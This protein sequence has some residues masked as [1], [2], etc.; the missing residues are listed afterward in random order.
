MKQFSEKIE[1]IITQNRLFTHQDR[2]LVALSGGA[3]SVALLR[4]LLELGYRCEAA[5]CNFQ[6]RGNES[7]R[8]ELFVRWLCSEYKVLL[9]VEHFDTSA[10][11]EQR[12]VSIEMAARELR[13]GFF[14]QVRS[15][16][17]LTAVAVAHH[18]DDN[19]ETLLLN[20][21]RGTGL[22]GLTGMRMKNGY[23]VRPLLRVSRDDILAYLGQLGQ[24]YVS[25]STNSEVIFKRNKVRLQLLPLLREMN[26]SVDDT[27]E[28]MAERL[29]LSADLCAQ[30]F[31]EGRRRVLES[32][33]SMQA[34]YDIDMLL[35]EPSPQLLL[36]D[37]LHPYGFT[38]SQIDNVVKGMGKSTG[39][40]FH[41][42]QAILLI[43]RNR[44]ILRKT[45]ATFKEECLT[46]RPG[47][48]MAFSG[49]QL[50]SFVMDM[51]ELHSIP[52]DRHIAVLD[53][54]KVEASLLLRNVRRGDRFMPFGMKDMK[55]V[56]DYLT[57]RKYSRFSKESQYVVCSGKDIIWLVNERPDQRYA[58][59]EGETK[60]VLWLEVS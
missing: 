9:H 20:L 44:L 23:V 34:I 37:L 2:V 32:E 43:D 46:F 18:K 26:P 8:D 42:S 57:N 55:L 50:V 12:K 60:R 15:E 47:S 25:D 59:V 45:S 33:T 54:D 40:E 10:Y 13:Y 53:A 7:K 29:S 51:K 39:A 28:R 5:H 58:L 4:V 17:G 21:I 36:F 27:L 31:A 22:Q 24:F 48:S 41:S 19:V 56:S 1:E 16:Y 38:P 49:G 14:E 35:M 30:V 3:D 52:R 11:A 6:L